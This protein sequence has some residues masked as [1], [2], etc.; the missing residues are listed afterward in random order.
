MSPLLRRVYAP[1]SFGTEDGSTSERSRRITS[2]AR[3]TWPIT[4]SRT[5]RKPCHV[6]G[7]LPFRQVPRAG[8]VV[9]DCGE[10]FAQLLQQRE[11]IR[12]E[13]VVVVR[14]QGGQGR[15]FQRM[16]W[17]N[18]PIGIPAGRRTGCRWGGP[19]GECGSMGT[20]RRAAARQCAAL[21]RSAI[22]PPHSF[23]WAGSDG[24]PSP[25]AADQR[26]ALPDRSWKQR[27]A[28]P[29]LTNVRFRCVSCG[30]RRRL[31][32]VGDIHFGADQWYAVRVSAPSREGGAPR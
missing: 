23:F 21:P 27:V 4:R 7:T 15:S 12:R 3:C 18:R 1:C 5:R 8:G 14:R 17:R 22:A 25:I 10:R 11:A 26:H 28:A 30:D 31:P 24:L 6:P 9:L 29:A 32:T 19:A 20:S 13:P 2:A 16:R